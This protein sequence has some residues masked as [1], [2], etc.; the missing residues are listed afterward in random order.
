MDSTQPAIVLASDYLRA[1]GANDMATWHEVLHRTALRTEIYTIPADRPDPQ[2]PHRDDELYYVLD[3]NA[4]I[5]IAGVDTRVLPGSLIYIPAGVRHYFHAL[6]G[7]LTLLV[8]FAAIPSEAQTS[9]GKN[10]VQSSQAAVISTGQVALPGDLRRV[11]YRELVR[12]AYLSTG[13]Y[14]LPAFSRDHQTPHADDEIYYVLSGTSEIMLDEASHQAEPGM[15]IYVPAGLP[16]LFHQITADLRVLAVFAPVR[17][18][19]I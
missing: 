8:F 14:E 18:A 7:N 15:L 4:T 12:S 13:V 16:H 19:A 3:G 10:G 5:H 2:E 6:D 11:R 9:N 17:R 1:V